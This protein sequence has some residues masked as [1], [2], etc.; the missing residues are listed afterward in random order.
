MVTVGTFRQMALSLNDVVELPHFDR[1]SFRV[2]KKIIATL[3]EKK[4]IAVLMFS[5]LQ[6]SVFCAFDKTVI[7]PVPGGWGR[8]GCTVFELGKVKKAMLMDAL[9]VAYEDKSARSK[10]SR[11][12]S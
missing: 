3:D 2:N 10:K 12:K 8:K 5:P 4:K 7:Y 6:Q 1:V 11:H 9:H